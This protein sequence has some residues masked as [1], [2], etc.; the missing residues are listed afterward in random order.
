M[1]MGSE[2]I[3]I[4]LKQNAYLD[5]GT[6]SFLIQIIL[7]GLLGIGVAV[8]IYW[9]KIKALFSKKKGEELDNSDP[10]ALDDDFDI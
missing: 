5:P 4:F 2:F 9:D 1:Q 10:T 6:G 8:R 3:K 7:A